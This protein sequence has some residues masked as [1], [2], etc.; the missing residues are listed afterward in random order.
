MKSH[1]LRTLGL[2]LLA[3]AVTAAGLLHGCGG[4]SSRQAALTPKCI[5]A[6]D[7]SGSLVCVQ[8]YCVAAC[9]QSKDCPSGQRCTKIITDPGAD[10][11]L[12]TQDDVTGTTCQPPEQQTC[13]YT[14]QCAMPLIC[15]PDFQCRDQCQ[16]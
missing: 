1:G 7:C 4:T 6:S 8:G 12:G 14:S 9:V 2:C 15:G 11:M 13:R 10:G 5:F 16:T 3:T